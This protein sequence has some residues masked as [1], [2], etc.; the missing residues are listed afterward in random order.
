MQPH[1]V[2]HSIRMSGKDNPAYV[3][4]NSQRYVRRLL[5]QERPNLICEW[6]GAGEK[7]EVHHI[8]HNREN[9]NLDNLMWLCQNCNL[10]EAQAFILRKSG[11][12]DFEH[13]NN[14][15]IVQFKTG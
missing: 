1:S 10:L 14:Q 5:K 4:G 9:N 11:R 2:R 8:D 7:V 15:L 3:N 6:C 13:R 12:A